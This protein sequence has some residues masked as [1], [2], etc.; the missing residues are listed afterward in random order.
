M[1]HEIEAKFRLREPAGLRQRLE[2]LGARRVDRVFEV[3]RIF[4]TETGKLRKAGCGLRLRESR[5]LAGEADSSP[6]TAASQAMVTFK[7]PRKPGVLKVREE[8]E[9]GV[10]D[11]CA[12]AALFERLGLREVVHYEKRRET[13]HLD[14]CEIVI[15]ELPRLGWFAEV[16]GPTTE[17]VEVL[18]GKLDLVPADRIPETYI[19]L[20]AQHGDRDPTGIRRLEFG[21][22][23]D[24]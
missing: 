14:E 1:P 7:G 2:S 3:N 6:G 8:I 13:W 16:E 24:K 21:Q 11:A 19:A 20:A 17:Q 4:D 22:P 5:P 23:E 12:L 15:D 10:A 9:T 18:S